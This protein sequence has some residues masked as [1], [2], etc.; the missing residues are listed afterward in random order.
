MKFSFIKCAGA[1]LAGALLA[2]ACSKDYEA[3][4]K[5]IEEKVDKVTASFNADVPNLQQQITALQQLVGNTDVVALKKTVDEQK[6][7]YEDLLQKYNDLDKKLKDYATKE[8]LTAAIANVTK[9]LED[10]GGRIA[11]LETQI[12]KLPTTV[13]ELVEPYLEALKAEIKA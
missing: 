6:Q 10:Q 3:D 12:A 8:E 1:L 2:V 13:K 7:K 9:D 4:I 11:A 5:R